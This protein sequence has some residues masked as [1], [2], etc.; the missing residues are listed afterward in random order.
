MDDAESAQGALEVG[1]D[2]IGSEAAAQELEALR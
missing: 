2:L 1:A